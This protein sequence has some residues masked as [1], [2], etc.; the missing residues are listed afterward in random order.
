MATSSTIPDSDVYNWIIA[1]AARCGIAIGEDAR[2]GGLLKRAMAALA[3][4]GPMLALG[5]KA[6]KDA[7]KDTTTIERLLAEQPGLAA[8]AKELL[9][10]D[11]HALHT[12]G[13]IALW[14]SLEVAVEDTAVLILLRDPTAV[15]L[16]A[17][18]G[19]KLPANLSSP[20][21]EADARRIFVRF[22][23]LASGTRRVS[24]AYCQIL[25]TL[26]LSLDVDAITHDK[27][28]ELNYV[29]NC[30]LHRGGIVD[31]RVKTEAPGLGLES[32][33][34]VHIGQESYLAYFDAARIFA[35]A[36]LGA[37][38]KSRHIRTK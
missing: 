1:P 21:I 38:V 25:E 20:L 13:V 37:A 23:R 24:E 33:A 34:P 18:S 29:R 17:G 32:G 22:D 35:V 6:L 4:Q 3:N 26:G 30:I 15:P 12:S 11:L 28:A 9:D 27:L 8:W 7:G 16:V 14:A 31:E 36:L 10:A 5:F 2:I 19:V